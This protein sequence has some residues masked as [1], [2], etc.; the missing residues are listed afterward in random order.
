MVHH[1]KIRP[2]MQLESLFSLG[3]QSTEWCH[4]PPGV[5]CLLTSVNLIYPFQGIPRDLPAVVLDSVK[6]TVSAVRSVMLFC[7]GFFRFLSWLFQFIFGSYFNEFSLFY[8]S[9]MGSITLGFGFLVCQVLCLL[10]ASFFSFC[11]L[12]VELLLYHFLLFCSC[13]I[14]TALDSSARLIC[15]AIV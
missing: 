10:C 3:H 6:L 7:P 13:L 9:L 2:I 8:D 15:S 11:T 5:M 12:C 1:L 4:P 14:W